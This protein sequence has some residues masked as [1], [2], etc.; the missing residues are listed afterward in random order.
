MT[1]LS[2]HLLTYLHDTN[3]YHSKSAGKQKFLQGAHSDEIIGIA[4]HPSGQIFATGEYGRNPTI[5]V[6]DATDMRV[7]TRIT[8]CHKR[9]VPLLSFNSKGNLLASVGLDDSGTLVIHDWVQNVVQSR[10]PTDKRKVL[11]MCFMSCN[12]GEATGTGTTPGPALEVPP[13]E[14]LTQPNLCNVITLITLF[15][16]FK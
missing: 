2:Y 7:L 14:V 4:A 6:W 3:H 8:G 5:I 1:T 10:T 15:F 12:M 9:G 11:A 16:L 13:T